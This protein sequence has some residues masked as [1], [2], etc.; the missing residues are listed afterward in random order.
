MIPDESDFVKL[1]DEPATDPHETGVR[2]IYVLMAVL[3]VIFIF[4][5][6]K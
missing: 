1:P 5:Y 6:L 4:E 3:A 2:L